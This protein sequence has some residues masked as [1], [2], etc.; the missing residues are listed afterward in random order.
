MNK[1]TQKKKRKKKKRRKEKRKKK[2]KKKST[3]IQTS[4]AWKVEMMYKIN[5]NK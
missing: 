5:V 4:F 1:I 2:K 3:D